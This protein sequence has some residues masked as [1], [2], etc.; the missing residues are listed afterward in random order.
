M[1]YVPAVLLLAI[2]AAGPALAQPARPDPHAAIQALDQDHNGS[3]SLAEYQAFRRLVEVRSDIDGA[4]GLSLAEFTAT[5]DPAARANA[6]A[7]LDLIDQNGNGRV[8]PTE[9]EAYHAYIFTNVLDLDHDGAWTEAEYR[10]LLQTASAGGAAPA[11][12]V[13]ATPPRPAQIDADAAIAA[14]DR[15]GNGSVSEIEFLQ[16]QV[17][18]FPQVD[19]DSDGL[20]T[21]E[22]FRL[23]LAP[24]ARNRSDVAFRG[25]DSNHDRRLSQVEF[26]NYESYVFQALL[27]R[28]RDGSWTA[29]EYRAVLGGR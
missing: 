18:R 5:L 6:A 24:A 9:Y 19:T 2:A 22:E 14:L 7:T 16:F 26:V 28:N 17:A 8:D 1:R 13:A 29:A 20:L 25:N 11:P 27:D 10:T 21:A 4:P 12:A 15:D 23:S 3:V